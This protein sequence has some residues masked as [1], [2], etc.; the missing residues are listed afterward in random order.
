MIKC[1]ILEAKTALVVLTCVS[2]LLWWCWSLVDDIITMSYIMMSLLGQLFCHLCTG[3]CDSCCGVHICWSCV[4]A[5]RAMVSHTP[6]CF[7]WCHLLLS[8]CTLDGV[9]L[10]WASDM[11]R[12][13]KIS[14]GACQTP[15]DILD[16]SMN[17]TCSPDNLKLLEAFQN[18]RFVFS[19]SSQDGL[20][21]V[22]SEPR[23]VPFQKWKE[24]VDLL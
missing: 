10:K 5:D 6:Y 18:T 16:Q 13:P 9:A 12:C 11:F 1:A 24:M 20:Y 2:N 8:V 19:N 3:V 22:S 7:S 23:Y 15:L 21:W 4:H 17:V 14:Q